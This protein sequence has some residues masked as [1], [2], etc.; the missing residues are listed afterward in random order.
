MQILIA[1]ELKMAKTWCINKKNII[2]NLRSR[3]GNSFL[4]ISSNVSLLM[5]V[6]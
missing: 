6:P 5:L 4:C 2:K 3:S 1:E